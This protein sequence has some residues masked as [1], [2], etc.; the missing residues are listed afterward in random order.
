MNRLLSAP[1]PTLLAG[2]ESMIVSV[3]P[4]GRS[5]LRCTRRTS[6]Q[7]GMAETGDFFMMKWLLIKEQIGYDIHINIYIHI[8]YIYYICKY[9]HIRLFISYVHIYVYI[10]ITYIQSQTKFSNE[11]FGH[12][13][14]FQLPT[15]NNSLNCNYL[16]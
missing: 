4:E 13:D 12:I 10:Y 14:H 3:T 1:T 16:I 8:Y 5:W 15:L 2:C 11:K 6:Y 9:V 7:P